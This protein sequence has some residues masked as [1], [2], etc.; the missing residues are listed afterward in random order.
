MSIPFNVGDICA[1]TCPV[2]DAAATCRSA[3]RHLHE[4][5]ADELVVLEG[6]TAV[7]MVSARDLVRKR[8]R[9]YR[10]PE[11]GRHHHIGAAP[12]L[13]PVL[14][15]D[16]LVVGGVGRLLRGALRG[17]LLGRGPLGRGLLC[18]RLLDRR[19]LD[20]GWLGLR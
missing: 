14:G 8:S 17:G 16:G 4:V 6:E 3:A 15:E 12:E 9:S 20:R 19:V 13:Q 10:A 2:I 11:T 18:G 5:L 1:R 7:G